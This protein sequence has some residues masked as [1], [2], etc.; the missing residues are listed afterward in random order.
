[1]YRLTKFLISSGRWGVASEIAAAATFVIG[2]VDHA[3]DRPLSGFIFVCLSVPLFWIGA[4]LAWLK[5]QEHVERMEGECEAPKPF[6]RYEENRNIHSVA[7][8]FFVQVEGDRNAFD[9]EITSEA[10]VA[11][12]HR[13]VG[14]QWEVPTGAIGKTPV[15]ISAS[16]IQYE[17]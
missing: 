16:C 12:N 3:K 13:R 4:Y 11:T 6:L 9:V 14:M 8:E 10:A 15:P 2:L 1:M 17:I 5:T 7:S